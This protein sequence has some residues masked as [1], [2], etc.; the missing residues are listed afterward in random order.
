MTLCSAS[1]KP[2]KLTH[3]ALTEGEYYFISCHPHYD[4]Y[5]RNNSWIDPLIWAEWPS[6]YH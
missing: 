4:M 5:T 3:T 6:L 2:T 1:Q